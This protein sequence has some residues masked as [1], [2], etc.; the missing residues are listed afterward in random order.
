[1]VS[2]PNKNSYTIVSSFR[3]KSAGKNK[4]Q[5]NWFAG[6]NDEISAPAGKSS[7]KLSEDQEPS[8][9]LSDPRDSRAVYVICNNHSDNSSALHKLVR[10]RKLEEPITTF[11]FPVTEA[12]M[13]VGADKSLFLVV[14]DVTSP[15]LK[16]FQV[17]KTQGYRG[18]QA[19][20]SRCPD[21]QSIQPNYHAVS[22]SLSKWQLSPS[23]TDLVLSSRCHYQLG[24]ATLLNSAGDIVTE[25]ESGNQY[26]L[27]AMGGD[28]IND[29]ILIVLDDIERS[30]ESEEDSLASLTLKI[31]MNSSPGREGLST[32]SG[33]L[34]GGRLASVE[35]FS[36]RLD[37]EAFMDSDRL[38]VQT[39]PQDTFKSYLLEQDWTQRTKREGTF[40]LDSPDSSSTP[41]PASRPSSMRSSTATPHRAQTNGGLAESRSRS[42]SLQ[43]IPV[44]KMT[45]TA[46]N[47]HGG[48]QE[49]TLAAAVRQVEETISP[50]ARANSQIRD[51]L[52]QLERSVLALKT[53]SVTAGENNNDESFNDLY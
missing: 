5:I 15:R 34:M 17:M 37:S 6:R 27:R 28:N 11:P 48:G 16:V 3:T 44:R 39:L 26:R 14:L 36:T 8:V 10:A 20:W 33:W 35:I 51:T 21:L 53:A 18:C 32:V 46:S 43:R 30:F 1:V 52:A 49:E 13:V 9:I 22:C 45:T 12:S 31:C 19:S 25:P 7:L 2:V 41:A 29:V 23:T 50:L 38:Q 47:G 42:V 4:Y 24:L 40:V